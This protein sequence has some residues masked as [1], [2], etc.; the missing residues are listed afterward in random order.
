[1]KPV[2][3]PGVVRTASLLTLCIVCSS[4]DLLSQGV[5]L[6]VARS[7]SEAT[8]SW[9]LS[10]NN[11]VLESARSLDAADWEGAVPMFTI[12]DGQCAVTLSLGEGQRYFRLRKVEA[13]ASPGVGGGPP[14]IG[15]I[16]AVLRSDCASAPPPPPVGEIA[17]GSNYV[18]KTVADGDPL[19]YQAAQ[20]LVSDSVFE[21]LMPIYCGLPDEQ[22]VT[23][24]VQWN[25]LTY[26]LGGNPRISGSPLSGAAYH[27]CAVTNGYIVA[28]VR[29][30]SATLPPLPP[31]GQVAIG[32]DAVILTIADTDPTDLE[33]AQELATD[34][35]F[36]SLMRQ[37][38]ALPRGT[39]PGEVSGQPQWHV[40]T[41]AA[42]GTPKLSGCAASGCDVHPCV[43]SR[44]YIAAVLRSDCASAPPP[45]PVGEIAVG[46][47]YVIK[48]VADADPLDYLGAQQLVTDAVFESLMPIYCG[49]PNEGCVTNRVQ[50]NLMTYDAGGNPW[51]SGSPLSGP[52][53]HYCRVTNG[54]IVA[55]IRGSSASLPS[56]PPVSQVEIGTDAVIMT[57]A[58][59]DP[60][61]L[62]NAKALATDAV[63]ESLMQ[64]YCALPRGT[65]HGQVS[66]QPQ[67][68]VA[69]YDPNGTPR[70]SACAASGCDV[71]PCVVS[72]GFITAVLR[73]ACTSAPVPPPPVG[74]TRVG[75]DYVIRTIADGDPMD[76]TAA[77]QI[78]TDAIFQSL[79]PL[80]CELPDVGCV[81]NRVQWNLMTYD[82][83]GNP[84]ISGSP[85]SGPGLHSCP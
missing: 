29:G 43:V 39:G 5:R 64:R 40:A 20:Q 61:D 16:T 78:V 76:Y 8:L 79:M 9:P 13:L 82:A 21:S 70:L 38:C 37:Y 41:H 59:G 63:F 23:N 66:G 1:M 3:L 69:T 77:Q 80:Y 62:D 19:D 31:V 84:R 42:D 67:W 26:D 74:Q 2:S 15:Y 72:R 32:T 7:Q 73:S 6:N 25:L 27:Y 28:V 17:V 56:P 12:A 68:H 54:F 85:L 36:E 11:F 18:I 47:N 55:V 10:T 30:S 49:L 4:A 44:G 83:G 57:I 58:D 45:P 52:G 60:A 46:S 35:V 75:T 53:F 33:H 48:T 24:R 14:T 51:I 22:C 50:W 65:G 34:E 81:T 71:H